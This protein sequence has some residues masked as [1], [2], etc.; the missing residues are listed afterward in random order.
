MRNSRGFTIVELLMAMAIFSF[1]MI[2]IVVA[3]TQLMSGYRQGVSS[4]RTQN[5]AKEVMTEMTRFAHGASDIKVSPDK[6]HIC[7]GSNQY[8]FDSSTGDLYLGISTNESC[9]EQASNRRLVIANNLKV[10]EFVVDEQ[11]STRDIQLGANVRLTIATDT[12]DLRDED[13]G[14][15]DPS[16]AGSQ[17]C[18]ITTIETA[19]GLRGE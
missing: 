1:V 6:S 17:Y 9:T 18:S 11:T 12:E 19:L 4:S 13:T 5:A 15:C 8:D 16:K 10:I 3:F 7:F 2:T 14:L